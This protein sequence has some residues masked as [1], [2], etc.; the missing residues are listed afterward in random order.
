[1]DIQYFSKVILTKIH[2]RKKAE[3]IEEQCIQEYEFKNGHRPKGNPPKG[4]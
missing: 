2:G 1:M 3:E 4:K